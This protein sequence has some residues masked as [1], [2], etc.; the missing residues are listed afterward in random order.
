MEI[1]LVLHT[2]FQPLW[3]VCHCMFTYVGRARLVFPIGY[4][5][6]IKIYIILMSICVVVLDSA[7]PSIEI[8]FHVRFSTVLSNSNNNNF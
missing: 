7:T 4:L 3:I 8:L 5:S 6:I 2:D 1:S